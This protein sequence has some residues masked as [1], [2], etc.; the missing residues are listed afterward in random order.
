MADL[1]TQLASVARLLSGADFAPVYTGLIAA[2]QSDEAV[3]AELVATILRPRIEACRRRLERAQA[4]GQLRTDVDLDD[5]VELLY[6]PIYYRLLLHTAPVTP[7]AIP[8]V[9]DRVFAGVG[10]TS[11]H[12]R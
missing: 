9:I 2:A 1:K 10:A 11:P 3:S 4:D 6:G 7:D 5:V 8:G 12:R